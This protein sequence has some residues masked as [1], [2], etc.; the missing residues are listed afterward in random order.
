VVIFPDQKVIVSGTQTATLDG[1]GAF[2]IDLLC[3]DT[4]NQQPSGWTYTVV[5]T[6]VGLK[7]RTY[8]ILLPYTVALIE[9][10]QI[11]PSP[12]APTY[13]PVVGP[14]GPPGVVTSVN[15]Y[16]TAAITLSS[17]DVGAIPTTQKGAA[18]GVASL[19]A[20]SH[21][22]ASQYDWSATTPVSVGTGAVGT[23][24]K[25]ARSDHVHDGVDLLNAQTVAGIKTFSSIPVLPGSDPTTANQAA[26]KSYVDAGV[27]TAVLLTGAQTVAGVKTFSSSPVVPDPTTSTQAATKNYID[28]A[29]TFT[30]AKAFT[31]ASST[32][33]MVTSQATGDTQNRLA[34][35]INGAL[36]WGTGSATAD[37]TLYRAGV[38]ILASNTKI[39]AILAGTGAGFGVS[40]AADTVDRITI[41]GSGN[42]G[43][44]PGNA[45]QD[46]LLLREAANTLSTTDTGIRSY[47]A[48]SSSFCFG[49]RVAAD[50][51]SRWYVNADGSMNW[52]SG[53]ATSDLN[54]YRNGV[55]VLKTDNHLAIGGDLRL[56]GGTYRTTTTSATTVSNTTTETIIGSMTIPANDLVVGADYRIKVW[57]VAS[58]TGTPTLSFKGKIGGVAGSQFATSG[59]RAAQT[60][61]STRPFQAE[62]LFTCLSTGVSGTVFGQLMTWETLS[63]A[64][65]LPVTPVEILDGSSAA[66]VNTT[67]SQVL[68]ISV[69]W[70]AAS[71]S[72]TLVCE[73]F[74]AERVS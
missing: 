42:I 51:Q 58:V 3:T 43:L 25:P 68:C 38:G 37:A 60:G 59:A 28:I 39:A 66:T 74:I 71:A 30:G 46:V 10:A 55:G 12:T 48:S 31:N 13:L 54:L 57:G 15:G 47:R 9:L 73:G 23:S 1:T 26:R 24:T 18:S 19:D 21:L 22:T 70:S 2:S 52:S 64:G 35:Q 27:A 72:N 8:Q 11:T 61:A 67:A 62:L 36:S 49:A 53:S 6:L 44:G 7:P 32:A 63:V 56:A 16:T 65:A 20:S 69:Q 33:N 4:S 14:Q 29:G 5:E 41:F 45:A 34:I 50:T 17:A 40:Q